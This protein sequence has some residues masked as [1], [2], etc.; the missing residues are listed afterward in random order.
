MDQRFLRCRALQSKGHDGFPICSGKMAADLV[1]NIIPL[2]FPSLH[3]ELSGSIGI[4]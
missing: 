3:A 1:E 2:H 4:V